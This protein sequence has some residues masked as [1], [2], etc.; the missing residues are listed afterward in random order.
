MTS[1]KCDLTICGNRA[2]HIRQEVELG[3]VVETEIQLRQK[4]QSSAESLR[5]EVLDTCD[6]HPAATG[7]VKSIS[8]DYASGRIWVMRERNWPRALPVIS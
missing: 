8:L 6:A 5:T 3:V 1:A 4:A 2:Q 7:T